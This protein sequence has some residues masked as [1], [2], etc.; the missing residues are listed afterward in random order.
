MRCFAF[1]P[2]H[3]T[4]MD[5]VMALTVTETR[6]G[7]GFMGRPLPK[8]YRR[9]RASD[10]F[11]NSAGRVLSDERLTYCE[12]FATWV[13]NGVARPLHHAWCVDEQG[14]VVDVTLK[15]TRQSVYLGVRIPRVE[16]ASHIAS[17]DS[18]TPLRRRVVA[19]R[20]TQP[21]P[22]ARVP[23]RVAGQSLSGLKS[24]GTTRSTPS[25]SHRA[26]HEPSRGARSGTSTARTHSDAGRRRFS[27]PEY[28]AKAKSQLSLLVHNGDALNLGHV[29]DSVVLPGDVEVRL[30]RARRA[31]SDP[32]CL[33]SE[34]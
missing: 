27:V 1:V 25:S 30:P 20:S 10:C 3:V 4:I 33:E 26:R 13:S 32:R 31:R 29:R 18:M 21:E 28:L 8:S 5:A 22:S 7:E 24:G 9:G 15:E 2:Q 11:S 23:A 17:E 12:G 34:S 16:N 19:G 6:T 14:L